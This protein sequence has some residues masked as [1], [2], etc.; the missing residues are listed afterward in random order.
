M[1][2]SQPRR[3]SRRRYW[4]RKLGDSRTAKERL[5]VAVDYLRAMAAAAMKTH[6]DQAVNE[7]RVASAELAQRADKLGQLAAAG[8]RTTHYD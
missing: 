3:V 6:P 1:P 2:G 4:Q 5:A 7:I 8:E